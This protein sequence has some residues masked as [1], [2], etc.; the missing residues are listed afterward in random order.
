MGNIQCTTGVET[1]CFPSGSISSHAYNVSLLW[2]VINYPRFKTLEQA[3]NKL[4]TIYN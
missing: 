4:Q 2:G 3:G 1:V